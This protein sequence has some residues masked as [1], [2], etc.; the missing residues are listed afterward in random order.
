MRLAIGILVNIGR[1][2]FTPPRMLGILISRPVKKI[3]QVKSFL[4]QPD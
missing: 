3:T 1:R 4:I 2:A